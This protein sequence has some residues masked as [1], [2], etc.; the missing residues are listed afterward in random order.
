MGSVWAI[1]SELKG[2]GAQIEN[3]WIEVPSKSYSV[4]SPVTQPQKVLCDDGEIW[5]K[6]EAHVLDRVT[7]WRKIDGTQ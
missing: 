4:S 3:L 2:T 6:Y 7:I 5:E 1:G